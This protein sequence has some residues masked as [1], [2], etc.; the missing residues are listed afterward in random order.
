MYSIGTITGSLCVY[1]GPAPPCGRGSLYTWVQPLPVGLVLC[2][3]G[4]SPSVRGRGSLYTWVQPL[5]VG[6]VSQAE[7]WSEDTRRE[8]DRTAQQAQNI[9]QFS[10]FKL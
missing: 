2:I 4:S 7:E 6:V 3:P 5:P 8:A 1:L 10:R 9:L